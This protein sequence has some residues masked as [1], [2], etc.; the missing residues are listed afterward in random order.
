MEN[1][2]NICALANIGCVVGM[3]LGFNA[4]GVEV[5]MDTLNFKEK[6]SFTFGDYAMMRKIPFPT[7]LEAALAYQSDQA[8]FRDKRTVKLDGSIRNDSID[9]LKIKLTTELLEL[10]PMGAAG[11]ADSYKLEQR[12]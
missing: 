4:C 5:W 6:I 12:K 1:R 11:I 7:G 9:M 8:C 2:L 10:I 3:D